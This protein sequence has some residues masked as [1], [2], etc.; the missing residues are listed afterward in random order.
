MDAV[1]SSQRPCL[2]PCV[3]P[4]DSPALDTKG[5]VGAND[6]GAIVAA[7]H[8]AAWQGIDTSACGAPQ[9]VSIAAAAFAATSSSPSNSRLGSESH[10]PSPRRSARSSLATPMA[11]VQESASAHACCIAKLGCASSPGRQS[12][13]GPDQ[14]ASPS[15]ASSLPMAP[16]SL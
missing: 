2:L 7:I 15:I 3:L 9:S 16:F 13:H 14:K 5:E 6:P 4:L 8:A 12:Q 10:S 1:G 11:V